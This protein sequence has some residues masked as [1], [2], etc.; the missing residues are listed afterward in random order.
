M[1]LIRYAH[2]PSILWMASV[3][4]LV[5]VLT[6]TARRWCRRC[7]GSIPGMGDENSEFITERGVIFSP[8]PDDV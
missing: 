5:R 7:V 3:A 6:L 4:Y 2:D 8:G 1:A